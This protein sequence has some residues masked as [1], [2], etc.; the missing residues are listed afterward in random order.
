LRPVNLLPT[1]YRPARASG[2]RRG[3]G[4][5]AIGTLAVLLVM[6]LLYVV[7][8]NAIKDANH[9]KAVAQSEQA[10]AQARAGQLQAYGDFAA[11]KTARFNAVASVAGLRFDYER[12][13]RETA[14]LLP[15][16]TYL[17][18]FTAT[19]AGGTASAGGATST[20]PSVTVT[21]CAPSHLAVATVVVRLRK[22]HNIID[23]DLH[24]STKGATGA[25]TTAGTF[26]A[27]SWTA[28]LTFQP[29]TPPTT[30]QAVPVRLGGGP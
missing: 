29:E 26:C 6:A 2:E 15:H 5:I 28:T 23:V 12:L 20:G 3:I 4:Y 22:L 8:N 14:L 10:A 7:T 18:Q 27:V 13:M 25:T 17:T 16:N 30:P 1:R 24:S 19:A 21:G 11:L 9:K